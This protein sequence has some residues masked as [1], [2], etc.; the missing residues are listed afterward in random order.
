MRSF[1]LSLLF[2]GSFLYAENKLTYIDVK[3]VRL[4]YETFGKKEDPALL[5]IMG[6]G[7][8]GIMWPTALCERLAQNGFFVIR[9][10]H[11][12]MGLSSFIDYEKSPYDLMD[13]ANDAIGILDALQIQKAEVVGI[14]MGGLI[15]TLLGAHFPDRIDSIVLIAITSD[16]STFLDPSDKNPSL[17]PKPKK[18]C[19]EYL[20]YTLARLDQVTTKEDKVALFVRGWEILN[21]TETYFDRE[22]YQQLITESMGRMQYPQGYDNQ[23]SAMRASLKQLNEA[24]ILI[25][26]PTHIIHGTQDPFFSLEHGEELL[27]SIPEAQISFFKGMGHNLNPL[28]YDDLIQVIINQK[29]PREKS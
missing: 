25:Q 10:D 17:L 6:G 5:L 22:L 8:Q 27:K 19:L 29:T 4:W 9:Y 16:F 1:L 12:D 21:G 26:V 14:S 20:N 18:E 7:C 3:D 13:L 28:F 24:L 23:T 2:C 11:R 15:A